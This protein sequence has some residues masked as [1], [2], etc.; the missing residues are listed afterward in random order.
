MT[1]MEQL[2]KSDPDV[3]HAMMGENERQKHGIELI[4]SEN[5]T[6]PEVLAAN[7][8]I[9]TNKYAEGYPG[10]RYYGGQEF[11]DKIETLAIERAKKLFDCEHANVQPLFGL[12]D[13]SGRLHEPAGSRRYRSGH[14]P[15]PWRPPNP[16]RTGLPYG[17]EFTISNAINPIPTNKVR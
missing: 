11:T 10:R 1:T 16:W 6:Y 15:F 7:G 14:G 8:S 9:F 5:Y 12:P 13:E 4:P 3:Y 17:P 2:A